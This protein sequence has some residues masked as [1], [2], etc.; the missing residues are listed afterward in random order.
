M[1]A[2][3]YNIVIPKNGGMKLVFAE[4]EMALTHQHTSGASSTVTISSTA[5][6][7]AIYGLNRA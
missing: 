2:I 1:F 7:G 5:I 3:F 4:A 6:I